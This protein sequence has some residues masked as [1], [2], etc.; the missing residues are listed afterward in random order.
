MLVCVCVLERCVLCV[1]IAKVFNKDTETTCQLFL[2]G[3]S[4]TARKPN[5]YSTLEYVLL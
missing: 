1:V 3:P 5:P 2:L 4:H